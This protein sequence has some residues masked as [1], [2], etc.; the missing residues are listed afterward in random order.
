MMTD[1]KR[2]VHD[3]LALVAI[4]LFLRLLVFSGWGLGDDIIY[5]QFV[6]RILT[7]GYPTEN[8]SHVFL[9]RPLLLYLM[10]YSVKLFGWSEFSFVLPF[11]LASLVGIASTYVLGSLLGGRGVGLLSAAALCLFPLDWANST[12]MT[13]DLL[14][15]ALVTSGAVLL[16]FGL[17]MW[18]SMPFLGGLVIGLSTWV[19]LNF[20]IAV[21]PLSLGLAVRVIQKRSDL[22]PASAALLGWV[23]A[24]VGLAGFALLRLGQPLAPWNVE[25]DFNVAMAARDYPAEVITNALLYYPRMIVG[26]RP[27][28]MYG[29]EIFPLGYFF[30]L[31]I[32]GA[33]YLSVR[34]RL[35]AWIPILS[36]LVGLLTMEFWPIQWA[37][38]YAPIHRLPRFLH[39]AAV[40]GALVIGL[41][42]AELFRAKEWPKVLAA[43]LICIL[44]V[45]TS[46]QAVAAASEHHRL[47]MSDLRTTANILQWFDGLV[48]TDVEMRNYLLFRDRFA[49]PDRFLFDARTVTPPGAVVIVGGSRRPEVGPQYSADM[50]PPKAPSSWVP[51]AWNDEGNQCAELPEIIYAVGYAND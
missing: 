12:T 8:W 4:S 22:R 44:Y 3:V 46:A 2:A 39:I 9:A 35:I 19:K 34:C 14:A 37:P 27:A 29:H 36:L 20:T 48:V 47:C 50:A 7:D 21:L 26:L 42:L 33:A 49:N 30:L 6:H 1:R 16:I 31:A 13:N 32:V 41:F 38:Y 45:V 10:A 17:K 43:G 28:G 40:P 15:S 5:S 18:P 23:L 24:Q 25:L 11:L 51:F